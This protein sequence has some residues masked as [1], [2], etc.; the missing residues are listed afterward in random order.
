MPDS[1]TFVISNTSPLFYL[2]RIGLLDLLRRLYGQ[3][4]VPDAVIAEIH[5][6]AAQGEDVPDLKA[7][8][9]IVQRSVL[10]PEVLR[11]VTD[12]GEGEAQ[13]LAL[14]LEN[15][16]AL[17]ILD[18]RLARSL[19]TLSDIKFTGT[20]GVLLRAKVNGLIPQVAPLLEAMQR[21]G[22]RVTDEVKAGAL[23]LSREN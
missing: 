22:F 1:A 10:V 7:L 16:K 18:D 15:P 8:A 19:A 20:I 5:A 21:A 13:V 3:V 6:G 9:W 4:V 12:L 2:H 14:A 17:A 11:L 23:R